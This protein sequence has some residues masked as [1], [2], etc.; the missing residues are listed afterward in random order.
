MPSMRSTSK[1]RKVTVSAPP[2]AGLW[3]TAG[4]AVGSDGTIYFESGDGPYD[5]ST[6][7]LSTS[8][9]AFT[10]ANDQLTLKDYYSPSNHVWL[11]RRDLDMNVTPVVFPLQRDGISSSLPARRVAISSWTASPWVA[12]TI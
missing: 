6:G 7:K 5:A 3:G 11:S 2:Q 9:E 4:P 8:V 1:N 10:F 12:R